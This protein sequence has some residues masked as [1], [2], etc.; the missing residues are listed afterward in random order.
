MSEIIKARE[1]VAAARNLLEIAF[2]L[3][4]R[5][6]AISKAKPKRVRITAK[7]RA[8]V[9]ALKDEGKNHHEIANITGLGNSGRVS[10]ILNGKR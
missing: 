8:Q 1:M 2:N 9:Q 10:E 7:I 3:M 5:E 4:T 6:P